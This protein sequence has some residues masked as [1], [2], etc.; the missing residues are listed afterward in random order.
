MQ[1]CIHSV[2]DELLLTSVTHL[3]VPAYTSSRKNYEKRLLFHPEDVSLC[4]ISPALPSFT[5]ACVQSRRDA[6]DLS[7]LRVFCSSFVGG[8]RGDGETPDT[9]ARAVKGSKKLSSF[10][11]RWSTC[12]F[13]G[14]RCYYTNPLQCTQCTVYSKVSWGIIWEIKSSSASMRRAVKV[15]IFEQSNSLSTSTASTQ[16]NT[17]RRLLCVCPCPKVLGG[18]KMWTW[19]SPPPCREFLKIDT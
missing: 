1:T 13:L 6:R 4:M 19:Q 3:Y 12:T 18:W 11:V 5:L 10:F 16:S 14:I 7:F 17:A 8:A 2:E 9:D 15:L